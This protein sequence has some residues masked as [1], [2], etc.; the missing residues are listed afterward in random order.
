[1][2][3]TKILAAVALSLLAFGLFLMTMG[4]Y[5]SVT[6]HDMRQQAIKDNFDT[7]IQTANDMETYA[8]DMLQVSDG[9]VPWALVIGIL[10][11]ALRKKG[12]GVS[13]R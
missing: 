4:G 2:Y 6:A 7:G 12:E 10:A 13:G 8:N 3:H 11:I 9:L 5:Y 1:M